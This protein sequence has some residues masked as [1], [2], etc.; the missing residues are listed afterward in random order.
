MGMV[1]TEV[2]A[3]TKAVNGDLYAGSEQLYR[4]QD[5]ITWTDISSAF[6]GGG[7]S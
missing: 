1:D 3:I 5:G 6:P 2:L 7:C 4:S